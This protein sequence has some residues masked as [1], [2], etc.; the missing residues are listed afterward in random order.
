MPRTTALGKYVYSSTN[1]AA[2]VFSEAHQLGRLPVIVS[3]EIFFSCQ[4]SPEV[5]GVIILKELISSSTDDQFRHRQTVYVCCTGGGALYD[6]ADINKSEIPTIT[7]N[8]IDSMSKF[9]M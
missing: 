4:I 1:V 9:S 8:T 2:I 5:V 7:T 3:P 6:I